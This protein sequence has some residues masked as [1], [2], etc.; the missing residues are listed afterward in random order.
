V[1]FA[2]HCVLNIAFTETTLSIAKLYLLRQRF[3]TSSLATNYIANSLRLNMIKIIAAVMVVLSLCL[4]RASAQTCGTLPNNLTNGTTADAS[5]VMANMNAIVGCI[6]GLQGYLGGLT[7]SNDAS[8]PNTTIDTAAGVADSD[9]V[10]TMMKL[11]NF[12]KNANATWAAGTGGGCLDTGAGLGTNTW[13]HLFVIARTDTGTVDELCS[14]SATSPTMPTSYTKKR[15]IGSFLTDSSGHILAF[16]Q[17]GDEFLWVTIRQDVNDAIIGT[18][19]TLY[20]LSVPPGVKVVAR[21][22]IVGGNDTA[23]WFMVVNSPDQAATVAN[24]PLGNQTL[25]AVNAFTPMPLDV[26]TNT[27]QSIRVVSSVAGTSLFICTY[28]WIDTRGK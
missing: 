16:S 10:T 25:F 9:D 19:A 22:D 17:N 3:P 6:N 28:G 2:L 11:A 8:T 13:Y 7:M 1:N 5:Q 18:T 23:S 24:V 26:R 12:T 4:G 14:T 27:S 15:R 20:P 21:T